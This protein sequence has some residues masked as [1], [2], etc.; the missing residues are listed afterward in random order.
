MLNLNCPTCRRALMLA[1]QMAGSWVS[2]P[3]CKAS[4]QVPGPDQP[5]LAEPVEVLPDAEPMADR[6]PAP[7]EDANPFGD[8]PGQAF[9]FQREVESAPVGVRFKLADAASWLKRTFFLDGLATVFFCAAVFLTVGGAMMFGHFATGALVLAVFCGALVV[10]VVVPLVFI[11]LGAQFMS[12]QRHYG[13]GL[14]AGIL[15][16]LVSLKNLALNIYI[17][18]VVY[19]EV[20]LAIFSPPS[21]LLV[22]CTIGAMVCGFVAGVKTIVALITPKV[23]AAFH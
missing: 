21:L 20:G 7:F 17:A 18:W 2:C 22:C 3:A 16:L 4:F 15:A 9:D 1:N 23:R 14:T 12:Q 5:T 6:F 13:V 10:V 8:E 11:S 19:R